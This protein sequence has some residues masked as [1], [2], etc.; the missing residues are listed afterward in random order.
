M[1][2]PL[3]LLLA[4]ATA[5][6]VTPHLRG[7][8][9]RET[10]L[11]RDLLARSATARALAAEIETRDVIVYVETARTLTHGRA[12]TRFVT[13]AQGMR[14]LRITLSPVPHGDDLAALLA[15]ELQHASEI[16]RAPDVV[17]DAG[18]LRLYRSIGEERAAGNAFETAAA[19]EVGARVR[20]ELSQRTTLARAGEL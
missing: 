15:H 10:A 9:A 6:P 17:D 1:L 3:V 16:A 18:I 19:R 5:A 14:Y 12:V 4:S 13:A 2:I 7:A 20:G 8:S 11:I